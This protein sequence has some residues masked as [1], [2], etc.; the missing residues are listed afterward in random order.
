MAVAI[1]IAIVVAVSVGGAAGDEEP[2]DAAS[3]GSAA[4]AAPLTLSPPVCRSAS[5][6]R[7]RF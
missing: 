6:A 4:T 7:A 5:N 2:A 1:V 3:D